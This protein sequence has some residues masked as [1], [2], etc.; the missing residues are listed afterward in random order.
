MGERVTIGALPTVGPG[1]GWRIGA[2]EAAAGH[3]VADTIGAVHGGADV[4]H[5]QAN[6]LVVAF[7][8]KGAGQD[9]TED[10]SPTLR[11]MQSDKANMN[12]GG[13]VAVAFEPRG[14]SSTVVAFTERGRAGG[15]AIESQPDLAYALRT[16]GGGGER[17][18]ISYELPG[19]FGVRRLTPRECERLQGFEDDWTAWGIDEAGRR[20]NMADSVRYRMT[21]NAVNR[22]VAAWLDAR[23]V[24]VVYT[25]GETP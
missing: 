23:L 14:D 3:I 7:T 19:D 21:G 25:E 5:A 20:I 22:K 1:A 6:R 9:V 15:A 17:P 4:K 16:P 24:A 11:A 8:S 2:D 10:A 18:L 13:Q 12:G